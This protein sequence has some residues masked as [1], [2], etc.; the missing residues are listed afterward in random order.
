MDPCDKYNKGFRHAANRKRNATVYGKGKSPICVICKKMFSRND[1][2]ARHVKTQHKHKIQIQSV[3]SRASKQSMSGIKTTDEETMFS[4]D[5]YSESTSEEEDEERRNKVKQQANVV[6]QKYL[7][8][9][10][11]RQQTDDAMT[12]TQKPVSNSLHRIEKHT[13][14]KEI[15]RKP[16]KREA[17]ITRRPTTSPLRQ[18][19][20]SGFPCYPPTTHAAPPVGSL[21]T[22]TSV[23]HVPDMCSLS[24]GQEAAS[25]AEEEKTNYNSLSLEPILQFTPRHAMSRDSSDQSID[26]D[27]YRDPNELVDRLRLLIEAE[28]T[29]HNLVCHRHEKETIL[30]ELRKMS[31]ID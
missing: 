1:A 29:G 24:D 4:L 9:L 27:Y 26:S 2:L 7:S 19:S 31:I 23:S 12:R 25:I 17:G 28:L 20:T 11:D 8:L 6:R 18:V 10:L 3:P 30:Q 15:R 16:I 21:S 5:S 14:P 22:Y 13:R